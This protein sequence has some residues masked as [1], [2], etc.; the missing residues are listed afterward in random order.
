MDNADSGHSAMAMATVIRFMG[1]VKQTGFM[2]YDEA[3]R[4]IQMGNLLSQNCGSEITVNSVESQVASML[5]R[6][7]VLARKIHCTSRARIG[8]RSLFD[9][10]TVDWRGTEPTK[11]GIDWKQKFL[12]ALADAGMGV[13]WEQPKEP[14][15]EGARMEGKN[16]WALYGE[17]GRANANLYRLTRH[18]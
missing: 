6:K 9:W 18:G 14:S 15:Y 11:D 5:Q 3:G 8:G 1:I 13:S 12:T 16:V 7:A 17:R 10:F 4:R 2:D